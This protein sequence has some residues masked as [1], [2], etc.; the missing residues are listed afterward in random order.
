M[1]CTELFQNNPKDQTIQLHIHKK[2]RGGT[3]ISGRMLTQ[4]VCGS[5][6]RINGGGG[7]INTKEWGIIT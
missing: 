4:H 2:E 5:I 1:M 3:S 7:N 6:P